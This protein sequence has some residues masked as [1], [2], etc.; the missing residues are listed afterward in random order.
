MNKFWIADMNLD[1][2]P[3]DAD[4]YT[5]AMTAFS[6]IW[7]I[8]GQALWRDMLVETTGNTDTDHRLDFRMK[9][10]DRFDRS[11]AGVVGPKDRWPVPSAWPDDWHTTWTVNNP[12]VSMSTAGGWSMGQGGTWTHGSNVTCNVSSSLPNVPWQLCY[13]PNKPCVTMKVQLRWRP[14][15]TI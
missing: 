14:A 11:F 7:T 15:Q 2:D 13:D 4:D 5:A 9:M 3:V 6:K 8:H 1:F 12:L 10:M